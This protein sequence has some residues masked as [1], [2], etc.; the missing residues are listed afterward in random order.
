MSEQH[1]KPPFITQILFRTTNPLT[2]FYLEL[3]ILIIFSFLFWITQT[4]FASTSIVSRRRYG[5]YPHAD[6]L[7]YFIP[8][9]KANLKEDMTPPNTILIRCARRGH[10]LF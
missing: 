10:I 9:K 7:F 6:V 2:F 4:L 3:G 8:L 5:R 1:F